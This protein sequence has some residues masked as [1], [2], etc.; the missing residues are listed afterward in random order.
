MTEDTASQGGGVLK[1]E[2]GAL[3]VAESVFRDL[4]RKAA[5]EV[6]GVVVGKRSGGLF[7]RGSGPAVQVERGEGEVAFSI[8]LT[9]RYDVRIPQLVEELRQKVKST[10]ESTTGYR[11]RAINV[12]VEHIL[13]PDVEPE[14]EPDEEQAAEEGVEQAVPPPA[15]E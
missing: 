8:S 9:V 14:A 7:R 5:S 4:A 2:L 15:S 11:V 1:Q 12:T 6:E 10:V 13:P 3:E